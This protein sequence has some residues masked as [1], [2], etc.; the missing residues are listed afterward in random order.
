MLSSLHGTEKENPP[1][2]EWVQA[3]LFN[4]CYSNK[5][6][7][8]LIIGVYI[9]N[10]RLEKKAKLNRLL[11]MITELQTIFMLVNLVLSGDFNT[12]L[13][14][15]ASGRKVNDLD[16]ACD[17]PSQMMATETRKSKLAEAFI[18]DCEDLAS[19]S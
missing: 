7:S 13:F 8:L 4:A 17:V 10:I 14:C 1:T 6:E 18:S 19:D 3:V 5:R 11:S 2:E 15:G 9:K 12:D 16:L